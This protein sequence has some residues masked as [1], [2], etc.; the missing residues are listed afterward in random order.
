[1]IEYYEAGTY[2]INE[3]LKQNALAQSVWL[4]KLDE[5]GT[6]LMK[7]AMAKEIKYVWKNELF[8]CVMRN[9]VSSIKVIQPP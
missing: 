8:K 6:A 5:T 7:A 3:F 9:N 4:K 1:M 2:D